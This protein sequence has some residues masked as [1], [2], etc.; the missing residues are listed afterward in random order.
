MTSASIF[1]SRHPVKTSTSTSLFAIGALARKAKEA[2]VKVYLSTLDDEVVKGHMSTLSNPSSLPPPELLKTSITKRKGTLTVIAEY[3]RKLNAEG[4]VNDIFE[5]ELMSPVFREFGASATAVMTDKRMGGCDYEDLMTVAKEQEESRGDVPGPLPVICSDL[6]VDKVQIARAKACGA[7]AIN[8]QLGLLG[9][10]KCKDFMSAAAALSMES[11]I[12]VN[13]LDGIK[14]AVSSLSAPIIL[15][16]SADDIETKCSWRSE[17]IPED[18]AAVCLIN[19]NQNKALE[20]VEE[21][22]KLRDG[23]YQSVWVS[24]CLFKSGGDPTEHA[25]AIINAMKSKS[26][27]KFASPRSKSGRGEGAREYLGDILM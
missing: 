25:G 5:P 1:I 23:G 15:I 10:E 27:V 8:L 18:V 7:G 6:I 4:F 26:S 19:A 12:E 16:N 21:A 17:H 20:E 9:E 14:L 13:N 11:V 22:W 24:D 2:E 3:K